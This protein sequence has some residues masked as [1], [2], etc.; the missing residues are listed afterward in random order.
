M[1]DQSQQ[2]SA[3]GKTDMQRQHGFL[4]YFPQLERVTLSTFVDV[5]LFCLVV[6]VPLIVL[7]FVPPF[8]DRL[9]H[10]APTFSFCGRSYLF[11]FPSFVFLSAIGIHFSLIF[12]RVSLLLAL[13]LFL[14]LSSFI[15]ISLLF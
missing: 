1:C 2:L 7:L 4:Q 6:H 12:F 9:L 3:H 14:H 5:G 8:L 13:P 11:L 10:F 15:V